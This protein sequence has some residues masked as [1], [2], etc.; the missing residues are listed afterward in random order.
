MLESP[1]GL[2]VLFQTWLHI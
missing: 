2:S 1:E